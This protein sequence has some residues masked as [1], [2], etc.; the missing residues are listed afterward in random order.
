MADDF[1]DM[2]SRFRTLWLGGR[3]GGGKTALA[4]ELAARFCRLGFADK[5]VSNTPLL[6]PLVGECDERDVHDVTFAVLVLDESWR[7]L[8]RRSSNKLNDWLAYLRKRDQ[9]LLLPSVL[10]LAPELRVLQIRREWNCYPYG[11][12]LWVYRW[13][14][15]DGTKLYRSK[16]GRDMMARWFWWRP[17]RVFKL[18]DHRQIERSNFGVFA[19]PKK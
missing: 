3:F 12:P 18:Y 1:V 9:I 17:D 8:G 6:L 4:V 11:V 14:L 15:D 7:W 16:K 2:V 5:I 19:W 13:V 10:P